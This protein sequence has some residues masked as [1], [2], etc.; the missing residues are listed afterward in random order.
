MD[1][2]NIPHPAQGVYITHLVQM[3]VVRYE[4]VSGMELSLVIFRGC[5]FPEG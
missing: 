5:V 1:H 3:G 2:D 4:L